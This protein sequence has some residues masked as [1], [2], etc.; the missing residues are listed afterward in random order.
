MFVEQHHWNVVE[1]C[2]P[3]SPQAGGEP[4][5][6]VLAFGATNILK[7]PIL[8]ENLKSRFPGAHIAGCSTS[9][10]IY[11]TQVFDDTLTVTAVR[12]AH[13]QVRGVH[14]ELDA[15][16]NSFQAGD[17]VAQALPSHV[18]C[19][20]VDLGLAHVLVFSDGLKVNGS[21]LVCGLA[22]HLPPSV[23]VTGGLAGDGA[24]FHETLVFSN[25]A[26]QGGAVA[27]LGLYSNR[28]NIGYGSMGGWDPFGPDRLITRSKNNVLYQL[29][30]QS[31]L[32]LYKRYLGHHAADL[33][34]AGLLFPLSLRT[35]TG[36]V[37]VVRTLLAINE[38]E[39]SM[40]F[41]GDLPE[42]SY[43]RLMKANSDRL[44]DGATGAARTCHQVVAT[45]ELA[46]LISCVGRKLVLKQRVEEEL[47]A[48]RDVL[49]AQ[50]SMT[51]FYSYGEICPFS[52]G[53]R[54]ELHNQTM[55]ITTF[56][57]S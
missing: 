29:D 39:Q 43:A 56:S 40:T 23:G 14:L 47:E 45:P 55:T 5:D 46:I 18:T 42:G 13:T 35:R 20:A 48:V 52:L 44:I 7:N 28:L 26:P 41:A 53:S 34:A 12:F 3:L 22:A 38:D 25:R 24:R 11:G 57:E 32:G 8:F 49:G 27:A 4:F 6:L 9:G 17:R 50:T 19:G 16:E 33:P 37:G 1:I 51:G 15:V 10:E 21:A 30:G 2:A 36:E 31:V 54:C